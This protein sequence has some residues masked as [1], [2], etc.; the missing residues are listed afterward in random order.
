MDA[1]KL[2]ADTVGSGPSVLLLHGQPGSKMDWKAVASELALDHTVI[3]PDRP[4]YGLTGGMANGFF[5]NA[6]RLVDLM[7]SDGIENTIVVGHSWGGGVAL[8]LTQ[9]H[10]SRVTGLVLAASVGISQTDIV[11]RVLGLP[12]A[13]HVLAFVALQGMGRALL[14]ERA[15]RSMGRGLSGVDEEH[16]RESV[17]SWMS[18]SAWRSFHREQKSYLKEISFIEESLGGISVPT[19]VVIGSKDPLIRPSSAKRLARRIAGSKIMWIDGAGHFLPLVAPSSIAEAVRNL[20]RH[21][22]WQ[23]EQ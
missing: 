6:D 20:S 15:R 3:I 17:S 11:D 18:S 4:G 12:I 10:P 2:H 22:A 21:D 19:I 13:G 7:D 16:L 1:P 5:D 9:R 14:S 23:G 8:A